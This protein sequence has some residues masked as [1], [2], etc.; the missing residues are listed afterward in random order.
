MR[1]SRNG[2]PCI[3]RM[4]TLQEAQ[5]T[6]PKEYTGLLTLRQPRRGLPTDLEADNPAESRNLTQKGEET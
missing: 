3:R 2:L 6:L 4:R 1:L 5:R